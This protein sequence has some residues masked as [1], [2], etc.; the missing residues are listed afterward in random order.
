[1]PAQQHSHSSILE[2]IPGCSLGAHD[3]PPH[4]TQVAWAAR[5]L[6][7]RNSGI[8]VSKSGVHEAGREDMSGQVSQE[9][10]PSCP[11]LNAHLYLH[12]IPRMVWY[13]N[14]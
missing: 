10:L 1:M 9:T 11:C 4:G 6:W 14:G 2:E 12:H 13:V 5:E 7:W 8:M 3:A